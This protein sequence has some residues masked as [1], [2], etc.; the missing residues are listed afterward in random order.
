MSFDDFTFINLEHLT[1]QSIYS[2]YLFHIDLPNLTTLQFGDYCGMNYHNELSISNFDNLQAIY[3]GSYSFLKATSLIIQENAELSIVDIGN[4]DKKDV[5][6]FK[7]IK[8]LVLKGMIIYYLIIR[9][10]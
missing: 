4:E 1:I 5:T 6:S 3:F 8:N 7:E 2:K 10:S 9:S